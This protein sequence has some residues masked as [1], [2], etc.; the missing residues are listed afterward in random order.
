[1]VN[2]DDP[3]IQGLLFNLVGEDGMDVVLNMPDGEITDDGVAEITN[4]P[5][6]IVRRTLYILFENR[7]AT[8]R[9]ERNKDSGWLTYLW[10]IDLK[11][12]AEWWWSAVLKNDPENL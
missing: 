2:L 11:D 12:M 9:R 4:V 8:Y 10:K 7:L 5:L 1:L 6:N 3:V